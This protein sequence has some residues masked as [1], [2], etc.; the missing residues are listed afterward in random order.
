[1]HVRLL[2]VLL[3]LPLLT[4]TAGSDAAAS[5]A[6]VIGPPSLARESGLQ[7]LLNDYVELANA[8]DL[9]GLLDLYVPSP[10]TVKRGKVMEG[11]FAES[12]RRAI[13]QW[14]RYDAVFERIE[15]RSLDVRPERAV[16]EFD[17]R[18][19]GRVLFLPVSRSALADLWAAF[20]ED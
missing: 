5:T 17:I 20:G 18:A 10:V 11:D 14:E 6:R 8:R 15:V 19:S 1:M 3:L 4:G 2:A 16:V 9:P 13:A 12:M 7:R